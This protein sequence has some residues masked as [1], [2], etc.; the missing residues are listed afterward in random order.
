MAVKTAYVTGGASGIG[1]AVVEMLAKR[2]VRVAVADVNLP[3]AQ[4][5]VSSLKDGLAVELDAASW[6][7]QLAAFQKTLEEFGRIDYVFAIAGI[8]EKR[9]LANDPNSTDFVKPDLTTLDID[10]N[11][12]LYTAALAIQQMRRQ[13]PDEREIRGKITVVA[14]VCGFYCVPTLP[15]YTAAKHGVVGFVRS[16]GKHLLTEAITL[17][18]ICPDV[19]RTNISTDAFYSQMEAKGLIVSM[20]SV[21]QAFE[22]CLDENISGETLEIEP[23]SGVF[24]RSGPE[25]FDQEAEE[26][27][28]LLHQR[29]LHLQQPSQ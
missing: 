20:E 14:S 9:W 19:V 24:L 3:G 8:G 26:T 10:L 5:V 27:L 17:N 2:G 21:T 13:E 28:K 15:I 16:Y 29:G 11:G 12:V 25:P 18:A 22:Q 23:K 6:E 4:Q 1:R 7:S